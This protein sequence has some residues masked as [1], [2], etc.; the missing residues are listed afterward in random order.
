MWKHK[1]QGKTLSEFSREIKQQPQKEQAADVEKILEESL[2]I[3]DE[4]TPKEVS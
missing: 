4:F 1:V 3:L 2:A